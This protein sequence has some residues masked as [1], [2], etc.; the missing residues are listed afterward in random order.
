NGILSFNDLPYGDYTLVMVEAPDGYNYDASEVAITLDK[1]TVLKEISLEKRML[2][3]TGGQGTLI[4]IL[5]GGMLVFISI[6]LKN[7]TNSGGI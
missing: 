4:F 5:I 3:D 1:H 7:K 2:P 6:I